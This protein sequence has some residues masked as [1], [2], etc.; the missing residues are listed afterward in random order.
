MKKVISILIAVAMLISLVPMTV[1]AEDDDYDYWLGNGTIGDPYQIWDID[2]LQMLADTVTDNVTTLKNPMDEG[3]LQKW[4]NFYDDPHE[5]A[6][7]VEYFSV[8]EKMYV[9][10]YFKLMADIDEPLTRSIGLYQDKTFAAMSSEK[11]ITD[12][13]QVRYYAEYYIDWD[14]DGV[15]ENI[16]TAF[17]GHFDG[18]GHSIAVDINQPKK[19][20]TGLFGFILPCATVSNLTV[21]GKVNGGRETGGIVG[22]NFGE[23]TNCI[24]KASVNGTEHVGGIVGGNGS[25]LEESV[26]YSHGIV[27]SCRNEGTVSAE[28]SVGGICGGNDG[29]IS[30]CENLGNVYREGASEDDENSCLGGVCGICDLDSMTINCTN[31]GTVNSKDD[32]TFNVGGVVGM[33]RRSKLSGCENTGN[34]IADNNTKNVG[35]ILGWATEEFYMVN[36][37]NSGEISVGSGCEG[38]GGLVGKTS[39]EQNQQKCCL[40]GM[41]TIANS[42]N[43]GNIIADNSSNIGG[44]VGYSKGNCIVNSY[45]IGLVS[46]NE[47]TNIGG[48]VG[49]EFGQGIPLI[50]Y[51]CYYVDTF[52]SNAGSGDIHEELETYFSA[53]DGLLAELNKYVEEKR[54][55]DEKALNG[56]SSDFAR[57]QLDETISDYPVFL[58]HEHDGEKFMTPWTEKTKLVNGADISYPSICGSYYLEDDIKL[59]SEVVLNRHGAAMLLCLNGHSITLSGD[60]GF[61]I[62][63]SHTLFS[64]YDCTAEGEDAKESYFNVNDWTPRDKGTLNKKTVVV[65]AEEYSREDAAENTDYVLKTTGGYITTNT[66]NGAIMN[67]GI[68]HLYSGNLIG[69]VS[70]GS[71]DGS[72]IT[73]RE[74]QSRRSLG[75]DPCKFLDSGEFASSGIAYM[76]SGLIAGSSGGDGPV[77]LKGNGRF[78]MTGGCI[79]AN[80]GSSFGAVGDAHYSSYNNWISFSDSIVNGNEGDATV[81][82]IRSNMDA[83]NSKFYDNR[84][85]IYACIYDGAS[86]ISLNDTEITGNTSD[87]GEV[88]GFVVS[89]LSYSLNIQG[90]TKI[91][92]NTA[93]GENANFTAFRIRNNLIPL[94]ATDAEGAVIGV[95]GN[96][97]EAIFTAEDDSVLSIL[98]SEDPN[99]SLAFEEGK[100]VLKEIPSC[101]INV[102]KS[103]R[104]EVTLK[105]PAYNPGETVIVT[106]TPAKEYELDKVICKDDN[107]NSLAIEE[108]DGK[109]VFTAPAKGNVTIT[110]T[111]EKVSTGGGGSVTTNYTVTAKSTK[112]GTITV[113]KTRAAS[114]STVTIT[115]TPAKGFTVETITVLDKKGNEVE[116]KNLGNNKFSFTMPKSDVTV[117]ATFMEDNT[118]LNF[119]VDVK[120]SDYFYDAVLWASENGITTGTDAVHFSPDGTTTRAQM[121]TFI[122]RLAGSPDFEGGETPFTD[123]NKSDYFYDAVVWGWNVGIING[124]TDTLFAPDDIVTRGEAVTFIYR[125][126]KV[127]GGDL[128]NP[129]TDVALG[130]FY[131]YPVLWAVSNGITNGINATTFG[132]DVIC[133]RSQIV[134]MLWR[135]VQKFK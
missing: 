32:K 85:G 98:Y 74:P 50:Y 113:D 61:K 68:F 40:W 7:T 132:P 59:D 102:L 126:A 100:I 4:K 84:A 129:F 52:E 122:W 133:D 89:E 103:G 18:N 45:N 44:I 57:W 53:E 117:S 42:Y 94:T 3:V 95:T 78:E 35:G 101:M 55:I 73:T 130:K 33:L 109:Y 48:L 82:V 93:G 25:A 23:V 96:V 110:A 27:S 91:I 108:Q 60:V 14:Q 19:Y 83:F 104:G 8:P 58:V 34:V 64:I 70:T 125:Y 67:Q 79:T 92:G 87:S 72:V 24:N 123:I 56:D 115:A 21:T 16:Y 38:I 6:D 120:A 13:D 124:K 22:T 71:S 12:Y 11:P 20:S 1:F 29:V 86:N 99:Y 41:A 128:P 81:S 47:N 43:T 106:V 119:F 134:T 62:E 37:C 127:A 31:R 116:V 36:C 26:V 46:G 76:H 135:F 112:N 105:K 88:G 75:S 63:E 97:G 77:A 107:G 30:N 9:G 114:G 28:Y 10:K 17:G 51:N 15:S 39:I 69:N 66:N 80:K 131:Y 54:G 2:D 121:V 111:F 5:L 65:T 49:S 118:M 90:D